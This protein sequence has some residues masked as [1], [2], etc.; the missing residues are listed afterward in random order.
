[1]ILICM[2]E[3]ALELRTYHCCDVLLLFSLPFSTSAG[4]Y[5]EQC[6]PVAMPHPKILRFASSEELVLYP[7]PD[8][9]FGLSSL[10]IHHR[11]FQTK[12]CK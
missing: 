4:V 5:I 3:Y 2:Q 11:L 8:Q 10:L 7:Q 9:R 6:R 1:M 12:H